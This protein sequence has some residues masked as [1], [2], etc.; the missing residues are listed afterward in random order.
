MSKKILVLGGTGYVGQHIVRSLAKSKDYSCNIV[1]TSHNILSDSDQAKLQ[2]WWNK[3][4]DAAKEDISIKAVDLSK[5]EQL[6]EIFKK[7]QFDYI[8]HAAGKHAYHTAEELNAINVAGTDNLIAVLKENNITAPII[9]LSTIY[10]MN[11]T[12]SKEDGRE[13]IY[14]ETKLSAERKLGEYGQEN[15]VNVSILRLTNIWGGHAQKTRALWPNLIRALVAENRPKKPITLWQGG[16]VGFFHVRDLAFLIRSFI[17]NDD[18]PNQTIFVYETWCPEIADVEKSTP[19]NTLYKLTLDILGNMKV[20]VNE[21][22]VQFTPATSKFIP[23]PRN[24]DLFDLKK[25]LR[26]GKLTEANYLKRTIRFV[27]NIVADQRT[28]DYTIV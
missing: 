12:Y 18:L 13:T 26:A 19:S 6:A 5:K 4:R 7:H 14:G 16:K 24:F 8:I 23:V 17:V 3:G 27:D 1:A 22:V 21:N 15:N 9:Y 28:R 20:P 10:V 2:D 11:S 25:Y